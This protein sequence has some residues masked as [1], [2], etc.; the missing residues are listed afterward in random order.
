MSIKKILVVLVLLYSNI[1]VSAQQ[2]TSIDY[3]NPKEY[4]IANVNISGVETLSESTLISISELEIGENIFIPGDKIKNAIKKLWAQGLFS[5][6]SINIDKVVG[7]N[8]FLNIKLKEQIRLS[9]FKSPCFQ[10]LTA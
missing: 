8:V 9:K 6:I 5:D 1:S 3:S 2:D 10:P 7:E 4:V